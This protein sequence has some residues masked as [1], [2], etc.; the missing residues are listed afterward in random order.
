[1]N[2]IL[3]NWREGGSAALFYAHRTLSR[4]CGYGVSCA[5]GWQRLGHLLTLKSSKCVATW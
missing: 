3:P 5:A 4:S 2:K 1:M